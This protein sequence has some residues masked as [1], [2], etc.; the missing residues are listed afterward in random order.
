MT[1]RP[2]DAPDPRAREEFLSE[3][4]EILET[5]SKDLLLLDQS[6]KRSEPDLDLLND[7]FRGVHTLKGLAAMFGFQQVGRLAHDV[8]NLLDDLRLGRTPLTLEVLDLCFEAVDL[9]SRILAP[10]RLDEITSGDVEAFHERLAERARPE[11]LDASE[12]E[13]VELDPSVLAVLTE[14]EEKRVRSA[15]SRG[16]DLAWLKTRMDLGSI[17]GSLEDLKRRTRGI[18]EI[19]T[20]LPAA[21]AT[22]PNAIELEILLATRLTREQLRGSLDVEDADL[23]LVAR[24]PTLRPGATA[25]PA[26]PA[27]SAASPLTQP[28]PAVVPPAPRTPAPI[29]TP[30]PGGPAHVAPPETP[31]LTQHVQL[32]EPVAPI[33]ADALPEL[34]MA[35]RAAPELPPPRSGAQTVR[36]DI[37]KL[38][39]L[40]NVVAELAVVRSDLR[41]LGESLAATGNTRQTAT[42]IARL[43]RAFERRLLALQSG[44]LEVRMVPLRQVF[45]KLAR[46]VRQ[47]ARDHGKEVRLVM[48]GAETEVDKLIIEELTDPLL[49]IVRNA[50]DHGVESPEA[51]RAA[52]K[53]LAATIALNAF[54]KG[55]H[56]IVEVDDDGAGM[57][58]EALARAAIDRGFIDASEGD[59]LTTRD[60][61]QLIFMPGFTTRTSVGVLSGRGV[62]L[63]VVKTNLG[64]VGGL[65]DVHSE[66]GVGSRFSLTLPVT[67]AIV[68]SLNVSVAGRPFVIPLSVVH[69]AF[70]LEASAIRVVDGREVVSLRDATLPILSLERHFGLA[71]LPDARSP[72]PA[73]RYVLVASL[74]A[75]RLGLVVDQLH[76]QQDVIVRPLGPSLRGVRG[77]AGAT[78]L[79]EQRVGLVLDVGVLLDEHFSSSAVRDRPG[80]LD[81]ARDRQSGEPSRER[82]GGAVS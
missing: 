55:R 50:I 8:E 75:Q 73:R 17:D 31:S 60:A 34:D 13:M 56:V 27:T 39:D 15:I 5:V 74:G 4:Q 11:R 46:V 21:G 48:T 22:D 26:S 12:L 68:P 45:D 29:A 66:L 71:R 33:H 81:V 6:L 79:G 37:R 19:L 42:E 25:R 69:E 28:P 32:R 51:R 1:F 57:D 14:F 63:D 2:P 18:A 49:H 52:G 76:G 61:L 54:Q 30:P 23:T 59:A 82:T 20:Y 7:V 67:L 40:M 70:A 3:A 47:I 44:I 24:R 9:L 16:S 80:A 78:D 43:A 35:R 36:V 64:R 65:V 77:F 58:P 10:E 72:A 38:D 62:G 41:R 53:P